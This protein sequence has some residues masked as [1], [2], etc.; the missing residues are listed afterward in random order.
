MDAIF[1]FL[2]EIVSN[3]SVRKTTLILTIMLS[4][5]WFVYKTIADTKLRKNPNKSY[6]SF[7]K[8][9]SNVSKVQHETQHENLNSTYSNK[10]IDMDT[11]IVQSL[12]RKRYLDKEEEG[13]TTSRGYNARDTYEDLRRIID[14]SNEI[15]SFVENAK[16]SVDSQSISSF[17]V[18][19]SNEEVEIKSMTIPPMKMSV[20]QAMTISNIDSL[21]GIIDDNRILSAFAF[22]AH[23]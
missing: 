3:P 12:R 16:G 19:V 23:K 17:R 2:K 10:D 11:V 8:S 9:T 6:T 14:Y 22:D 15:R 20:H 4:I 18:H 5:I 13:Q 21:K 7:P 1:E